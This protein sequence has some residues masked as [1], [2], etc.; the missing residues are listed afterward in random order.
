MSVWAQILQHDFQ[1]DWTHDTRESFG[2]RLCV[3]FW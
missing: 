2:N 1:V 3:N